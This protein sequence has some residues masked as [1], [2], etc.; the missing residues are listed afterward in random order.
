MASPK[1]TGKAAV[2]VSLA[3]RG[4]VGAT[5]SPAVDE[6]PAHS[7]AVDA[8]PL[9]RCAEGFQLRLPFSCVA[10]QLADF[11]KAE[12]FVCESVLR[13]SGSIPEATA[14]RGVPLGVVG[15]GLKGVWLHGQRV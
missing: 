2:V 10:R 9:A 13:A 8:D 6:M 4:F 7:T 12:V 1:P 15:V 14:E 5:D 3:V 11:R